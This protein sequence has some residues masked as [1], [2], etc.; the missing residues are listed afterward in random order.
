[1][2]NKKADYKLLLILTLGFFVIIPLAQYILSFIGLLIIFGGLKY[3]L[4]T[5]SALAII[6]IGIVFFLIKHFS[7]KD[8]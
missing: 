3:L 5:V 4:I 7:R 6:T 2:N 8:R 1:M